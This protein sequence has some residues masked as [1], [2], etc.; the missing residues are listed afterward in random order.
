MEVQCVYYHIIK[1]T[2][3]HCRT[4][5]KGSHYWGCITQF[6]LIFLRGIRKHFKCDEIHSNMNELKRLPWWKHSLLV[7]WIYLSFQR[8]LLPKSW[9]VHTHTQTHTH[10]CINTHTYKKRK[11]KLLQFPFTG[12]TERHQRNVL[13]FLL[14]IAGYAQ[15]EVLTAVFWLDPKLYSAYLKKGTSRW[16]GYPSFPLQRAKA[17]IEDGVAAVLYLR[18]GWISEVRE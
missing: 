2:I 3:S 4:L 8:A 1:I 14:I 16:K 17:H 7:V 10:S 13:T 11:I 9:S 6:Y 5:W 18:S 12:P 15:R